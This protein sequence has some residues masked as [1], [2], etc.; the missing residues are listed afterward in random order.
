MDWNKAALVV[1]GILLAAFI[2]LPVIRPANKGNGVQP[3]AAPA[4]AASA[5][6]APVVA[7]GPPLT[8]ADIAGSTWKANA[9]KVGEIQVKFNADGTCVAAPT[10]ALIAQ[11]MQ[12]QIGA[13]QITGTWQV[14]GTNLNISASAGGQSVNI[15]GQIQGQSLVVNGTAATRVQ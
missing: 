11:M 13:S 4:K 8:A 5:P 15:T 12:M 7:S 14:S 1:G 10:S 3:A 2:A 6:A 9:P